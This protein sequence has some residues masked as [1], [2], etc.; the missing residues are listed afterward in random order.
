MNL[1]NEDDFL[2]VTER[3]DTQFDENDFDEF[4]KK[5]ITDDEDFNDVDEQVTN[6]LFVAK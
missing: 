4:E 3:E 5:P 1:V 6:N 2:R